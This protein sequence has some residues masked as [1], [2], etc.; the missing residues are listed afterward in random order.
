MKTVDEYGQAW[1]KVPNATH[2]VLVVDQGATML[3][4]AHMMAMRHTCDAAA[5]SVEIYEIPLDE[6]P[7]VCQACHLAEVHRPK[8]ILH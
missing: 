1:N 4:E 3:C 7:V 2:L 5:I 8:I 6:E